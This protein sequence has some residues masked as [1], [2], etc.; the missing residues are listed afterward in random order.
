[1]SKEV[2]HLYDK[3]HTPY[4]KVDGK[5]T[6]SENLADLGGVAIALEALKA[7]LTGAAAAAVKK[8]YQEFFISYA[9]SWRTKQRPEKA[10]QALLLDRHA[11]ADLR[12]N[13]VVA[14]FTEFYE[15]FSLPVPTKHRI[16]FW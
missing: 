9:V 16:V 10:K 3:Q 11:P 4:G 13:L 2:E 5:H 8:A 15:A 14:Q 1:M 12:V 7:E 6:L